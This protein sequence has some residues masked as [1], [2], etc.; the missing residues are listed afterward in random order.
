MNLRFS[1]IA[2][3]LALS[4]AA[5]APAAVCPSSSTSEIV[6][7][8]LKHFL[9]CKGEVA[10]APSY[11]VLLGH[12]NRQ[13][14]ADQMLDRL[15]ENGFSSV[16]VADGTNYRIVTP[17]F[18]D[19]ATAEEMRQLLIDTGV[20]VAADD[21]GGRAGSHPSRGT[22]EDPRP[23]GRPG[24]DPDPGGARL[25]CGDRARDDGG[26]GGPARRPGCR[27][28][29]VLPDGRTAGGRLSG[30]P[31]NRGHLAFGARPGACRRRFL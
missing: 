18:S 20:R 3:I 22:V 8:G 6:A 29:R 14:D 30:N 1:T 25:R 12:F 21:P 24:N 11:R 19:R 15:Q 23:R 28:R 9:V 27:Q 2:S 17:G 5:A 4:F 26:A 31:P 13:A 10:T 16:L 7:P